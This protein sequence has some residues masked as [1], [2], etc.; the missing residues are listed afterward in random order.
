MWYII[1]EYYSGIKK[2]K[3]SPSAATCMDLEGIMLCEISQ[4]EKERQILY[5]IIYMWNLNIKY[6]KL[7]SSTKNWCWNWSS[8]TLANWCE[9][10]THWIRPWC[11]QRLR[12]GGK[13]G[14]W[15]WDGW[16][17]SLTSWTWVWANSR[18]RWWT[19][20]PGMLQST[21]SQR[22]EHDLATEQQQVR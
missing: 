21:G 5:D 13:G 16:M 6:F 3:I 15:G 4:A 18:R 8:K 14:D 10:P 12:A 19:E 7:V 17:A 1:R 9:E 11:W 2:N 22:V 20:K